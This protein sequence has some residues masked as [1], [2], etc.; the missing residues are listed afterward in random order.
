LAGGLLACVVIVGWANPA[1]AQFIGF[2]IDYG[3]T[4]GTPSNTYGAA[5]GQTGFWNNPN[6]ALGTTPVPLS[7]LSGTTTSVTIQN[8][9]TAGI[10]SFDNPDTVGDDGALYDD[11][12]DVGVVGES[13]AITISGLG[14][15]LYDVYTYAWA[16]DDAT[17]VSGVSVNGLPE[18]TVGGAWPGTSTLGVTYALH[19]LE[20]NTGED[21]VIVVTTVTG[22]GSVNGI[23]IVPV[24]E[25]AS[26]GLL[27]LPVV[28][29]LIWRKRRQSATG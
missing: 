23:Q 14:A 4:A 7:D 9:P 10:F 20:L 21:L 25:P 29:G 19:S 2:N 5:S 26:L 12:I 11:F 15:G 24:P 6:P 1:V 28:A 8:S 3:T 22:F 17:F 18:Q 27:S 13:I 16:S